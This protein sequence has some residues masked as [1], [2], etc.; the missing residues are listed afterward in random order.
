[1]ALKPNKITVDYTEVIGSLR[2]VWS[3][4]GVTV[5]RRLECEWDDAPILAREIM[6]LAISDG[7]ATTTYK[8]QLYELEGVNNLYAYEAEIKGVGTTVTSPADAQVAEYKLAFVSV[9]YGI[10]ERADTED[11]TE[12]YISE[13]LT[14]ATEFLTL[15]NRKLFWDANQTEEVESGES[16]AIL[17]PMLEWTYTLHNQPNIPTG[18]LELVGCVNKK[19]VKSGELGI[20]FAAGTLLCANPTATREVTS[21][22]TT[23][24]A[25]HCRFIWR[26]EGWN[27]M[28]RA[29]KS[30]GNTIDWLHHYTETG[31][32]AAFYTEKNF[33]T[34]VL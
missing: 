5:E 32:V 21:E 1:M 7:V 31:K 18:L 11:A 15:S 19:D 10:P 17:I 25:V 9:R 4:T 6:G 26:K 27:Y 24:W 3:S 30:D 28:P 8:P 22:G 23:N 13:T 14:G 29:D 20:T 12:T 34:I 16:P 33:G 2:I